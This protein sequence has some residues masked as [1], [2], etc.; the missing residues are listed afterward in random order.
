MFKLPKKRLTRKR[1]AS[2]EER[3]RGSDY[4]QTNREC[5]PYTRPLPLHPC[6]PKTVMPRI[7]TD[8]TKKQL[9]AYAQRYH[10]EIPKHVKDPN[11]GAFRPPLKDEI[12]TFITKADA[13]CD[14]DFEPAR[15]DVEHASAR[16]IDIAHLSQG[17]DPRSFL[18]DPSCFTEVNGKK[19]RCSTS[20]A[21]AEAARKALRVGIKKQEQQ[22]RAVPQQLK[23][24][25]DA[26][27]DQLMDAITVQ[28]GAGDFTV[29]LA[30]LS[31]AI[32]PQQVITAIEMLK[33]EC[34]ENPSLARQV[35]QAITSASANLVERARSL[36]S[37][38]KYAS[39]S[40]PV[41][42]QQQAASVPPLAN[43]AATVVVPT[44]PAMKKE[45]VPVSVAAAVRVKPERPMRPLPPI[46][47]K[48][49]APPMP[50]EQQ[51]AELKSTTGTMTLRRGEIEIE[52]KPHPSE[53]SGYL[54]PVY[55]DGGHLRPP[56]KIVIDQA[57]PVE[58]STR[59]GDKT[60][61]DYYPERAIFFGCEVHSV[62]AKLCGRV[63]VTREKLGNGYNDPDL[64][65]TTKLWME[66]LQNYMDMGSASEFED[67]VL[68]ITTAWTCG[69]DTTVKNRYKT[70]FMT[71]L[72]ADNTVY[73]Y[74]SGY[75]DKMYYDKTIEGE[76]YASFRN[77]VLYA[78]KHKLESSKSVKD[79]VLN[80]IGKLVVAITTTGIAPISMNPSMLIG[81][82]YIKDKNH[83]IDFVLSPFMRPFILPQSYQKLETTSQ[84]NEAGDKYLYDSS[85]Y[86]P[87]PFELAI[88][89]ILAAKRR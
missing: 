11:T 57:C 9:L 88:D 14:M 44:A 28:S 40:P 27:L 60:I 78:K 2:H 52:I 70:G 79:Y 62:G 13:K 37:F 47:V 59:P 21:V 48:P 46:P 80:E 38:I 22:Q 51:L 49:S 5:W 53:Y 20:A 16:D 74:T 71:A 81:V 6:V 55:R 12:M 42:V 50:Q 54:L 64:Q 19:R 8:K 35:E 76:Q 23:T 33:E 86:D 24:F 77:T 82:T 43:P 3:C 36:S 45:E 58:V 63:V 30:A 32:N 87:K 67:T 39:K 84:L 89:E 72:E 17:R 66:R 83:F 85:W 10:I 41:A 31:E 4:A 75:T 61:V 73:G 7:M 29:A 56:V 25:I 1:K 26:A 65:K 69:G 68:T 34:K 15:F 18:P